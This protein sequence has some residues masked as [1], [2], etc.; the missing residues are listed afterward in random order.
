MKKTEK[1][2]HHPGIVYCNLCDPDHIYD[3]RYPEK[4]E[5]K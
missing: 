4:K 2:C 1:E 5:K 3:Y